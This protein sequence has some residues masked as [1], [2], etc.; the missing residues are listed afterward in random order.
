MATGT[1]NIAIGYGAF[2]AADAGEDDCIAI[3]LNALGNLNHAS[4]IKNI[5][6]GSGAGDGMGTLGSADNILIGKDAGGGTWTT[7]ASNSNVSV[8]NGSMVAAMNGSSDNTAV[9]AY[10]LAAITE[11]DNTVAIGY[12]AGGGLTTGNS[13]TIVGQGACDTG[14]LTADGNVVVGQAT[15]QNL[16]GGALNTIIGAEA[17][18]DLVAGAN[19]VLVG[20]YAGDALGAGESFNISIGQHSMGS[21]DEGTNGQVDHNIAIGYQAFLGG[22]MG[23]ASEA[24]V[25]NIAIGSYALDAT[26]ADDKTGTIAIGYNAL[27]SNTGGEGNIAIGYGA[28]SLITSGVNNTCVGYASGENLTGSTNAFFGKNSGNGATGTNSSTGIGV[29]ALGGA[30][31]TGINNTA[32][33]ASAGGDITDG[34]HNVFIG[35]GAGSTGVSSANSDG[36]ILIG[37]GVR[38]SGGHVDNEIVFGNDAAGQGTNTVLLGNGSVD[39]SNGLFCADTGIATP[40]DKRIKDKIKD[41]S[42]GL[43]YINKLRTVTYQ[44]RHPQDYPEELRGAFGDAKKPK[45][46]VAKTE[47]GLISQEVKA[48]MDEMELDIQGHHTNPQ[49]LQ[50]VKYVSFIIPLVKAVQELSAKVKALE[51]AQ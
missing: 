1:N 22:N 44:K 11:G 12:G 50:T 49:G 25:G 16:A 33:G 40:S 34:T 48:V 32:L 35:A 19:N 17:G 36:C 7:A 18:N 51:D 37:S 31:M 47:V 6:I 8:G 24:A 41:N 27:T 30:T 43:D 21:W 15:A 45:D 20:S 3:G 23:T 5:A 26:S 4:S 13:N 29:S 10:S 14:T 39:S 46:W 2:D 38:Q 28:G 42:T 9:G